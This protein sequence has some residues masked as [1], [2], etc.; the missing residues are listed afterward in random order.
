[1]ALRRPAWFSVES[2]VCEN[3]RGA[4]FFPKKKFDIAAAPARK[5]LKKYD[6]A[7]APARKS[8]LP[9]TDK[10]GG[11]PPNRVSLGK[12]GKQR[13]REAWLAQN[14]RAAE[15]LE[16]ARVKAARVDDPETTQRRAIE[17]RHRTGMAASRARLAAE[18]ATHRSLS[19]QLFV[20]LGKRG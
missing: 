7:A 17:A 3:K 11:G 2:Q 8:L 14:L 16:A 5:S 4:A 15:R 10:Q 12:S 18:R 20:V 6:I 1:M 9:R 19:R 13:K